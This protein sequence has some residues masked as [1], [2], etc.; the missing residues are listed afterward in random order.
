MVSGRYVTGK[1][2]DEQYGHETRYPIEDTV[3]KQF[4]PNVI[5]SNIS[6]YSRIL[7]L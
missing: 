1:T 2:Y 7:F 6:V 4:I 5:V 3:R